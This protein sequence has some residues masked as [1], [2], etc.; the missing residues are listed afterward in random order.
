MNGEPIY[1]DSL[2]IITETD[3]TFLNY[4][5]PSLKPKTVELRDIEF[6][7]IKKPTLLTGK[8]RFHGSGKLNRWYPKDFKRY[9]CDRIF[10]LKIK[11]KWMEI[12]FTVE[13][14]ERV[15]NILKARTIIKS[16]FQS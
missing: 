16:D 8:W 11:H 1:R 9:K 4:Y 3:I 14:G 2:V 13:D 6:I 10:F 7:E 5:Y 12:G 15:K